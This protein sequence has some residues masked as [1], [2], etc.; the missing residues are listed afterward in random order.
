MQIEIYCGNTKE[1]QLASRNPQIEE[2]EKCIKTEMH[3][4]INAHRRHLLLG[5]I[6]L[7][8]SLG[9]KLMPYPAA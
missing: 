2:V 9:R 4:G 7:R 1:C 3:K 8:S 6:S 5:L